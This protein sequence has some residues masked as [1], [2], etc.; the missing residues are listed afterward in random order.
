MSRYRAAACNQL[1]NASSAAHAASANTCQRLLRCR[2]RCFHCAPSRCR[3]SRYCEQTPC[4][5]RRARSAAR[6]RARARQRAT[7]PPRACSQTQNAPCRALNNTPRAARWRLPHHHPPHTST[8]IC[9]A[10]AAADAA[11]DTVL[12][13]AVDTSVNREREICQR[14]REVRGELTRRDRGQQLVVDAGGALRS[15]WAA[16]RFVALS[17]RGVEAASPRATKDRELGGRTKRRHDE[18]GRDLHRRQAAAASTTTP[19]VAA[20][21]ALAASSI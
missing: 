17:A 5:G 2:R 3:V 21:A 1:T 14:A 15:R 12:L 19:V 7:R 10:R 16:L 11:A 9:A 13:A 20:L 18:C 4:G 6:A 8:N